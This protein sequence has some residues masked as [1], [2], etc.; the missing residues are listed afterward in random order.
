LEENDPN[1][2]SRKIM[3]P[4]Y[5]RQIPPKK[6][7]YD[8]VIGPHELPEAIVTEIKAARK[9]VRKKRL[10]G[11]LLAIGGALVTGGSYVYMF[12]DGAILNQTPSSIGKG[13]SIGTSAIGGGMIGLG[14][15][16]FL[17]S[18]TEE[19]RPLVMIKR[20]IKKTT[21]KPIAGKQRQYDFFMIDRHNRLILTNYP[22][23]LRTR[24]PRRAE[25][26]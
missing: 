4:G 24:I 22:R 9:L 25:Y 23:R 17:T 12:T 26:T 11:G 3:T 16:L 1:P 13:V 7:R 18:H 21:A 2:K 5:K 20:W 19:T 14:S 10:K 6:I 8:V 15:T